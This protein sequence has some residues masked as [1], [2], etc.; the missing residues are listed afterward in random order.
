MASQNVIGFGNGTFSAHNHYL[1]WSWLLMND[2][3]FNRNC[4]EDPKEFICNWKKV[5]LTIQ[6]SFG[7]QWV[8]YKKSLTFQSHRI[9]H[10]LTYKICT[11]FWFDLICF[12]VVILSVSYGFMWLIYPY[13][14]GLL[15]WLCGNHMIAPVPE[16]WPWRIMV[17]SNHNSTQ[18]S[19]NHAQFF[20]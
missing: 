3:T 6:A 2:N 14:S 18:Q 12:V 20:R 10:S 8:N 9:L 17:K 11:W 16:K 1:K 4:N 15:L 5:L 7:P 19:V 13:T